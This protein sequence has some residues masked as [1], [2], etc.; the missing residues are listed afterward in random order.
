M[1]H[2]LH[3]EGCPKKEVYN[4]KCLYIKADRLQ[5]NNLV[6]YLESLEKQ[7]QQ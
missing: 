6:M 2:I 1:K 5:I 3:D 4:T 7:Q